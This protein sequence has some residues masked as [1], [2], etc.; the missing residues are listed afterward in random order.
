MATK[1]KATVKD[2]KSAVRSVVG[3]MPAELRVD[4]VGRF[5]CACDEWWCG[6]E[7]ES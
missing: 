1:T 4:N 6:R 2:V 7:V 3:F 5:G